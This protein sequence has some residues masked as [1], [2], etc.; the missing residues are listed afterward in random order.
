M[1]F[2]PQMITTGY[3]VSTS[4]S[5]LTLPHTCG[6]GQ[7]TFWDRLIERFREKWPR[8]RPTQRK[9]AALIGVKQPSVQKWKNGGYPD[10][11][12]AIDLARRLD[13]T[14]EWLLTGRGSKYPLDP[15]GFLVAEIIRLALQ[16]SEPQQMDL[17][18]YARYI[19]QNPSSVSTAAV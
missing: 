11:E 4:R 15:P 5:Y 19:L 6:M 10:M 8:V 2:I 9:I 16:M 14:V 7:Q 1:R 18:K 12:H 3:H 17:V 13:V